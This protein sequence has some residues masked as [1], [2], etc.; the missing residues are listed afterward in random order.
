MNRPQSNR[1]SDA[2]EVA[3][4]VLIHSS[5]FPENVRRDLLESLRTRALNH[6]FHYDSIKQAQKWLAV[7]QAY[8]PAQ[9]DDGCIA[10]Y[11]RSV[12][13][14]AAACQ[15]EPELNVIGLGCGSGQKEV[16]LLRALHQPRRVVR[17]F[18][19]DASAAMVLH[20]TREARSVISHQRCH[21]FVFD[22]ASVG[23]L[24]GALRSIVPGPGRRAVTFFGMLPNFEPNPVLSRLA[25]A[26]QPDDLLLV[27][28]NLAP[29]P[30]Y[31]RGIKR[32]LPQYDNALTR[33]WLLTFLLDL[34]IERAD[35]GIQF[36]IENCP[37][38]MGLK[39][40]A[41]YFRFSRDRQIRIGTERF[42]VKV[43]AEFRLFFSYRY[44]PGQLQDLLAQHRLAVRDQWTTSSGEEGVFYCQR[45]RDR[46]TGASPQ[47]KAKRKPFP[48]TR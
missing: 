39:R 6:K 21:P 18:P 28:A 36:V 8:S 16:R 9:T 44:T 11:E 22:L 32:V 38:A 26:M 17:Y 29:G 23:D 13:A 33:D 24:G 47:T 19:C 3:V 31:L 37:T 10:I 5:Q 34:G 15:G 35:G 48:P 2:P 30:D 7:H 40:I 1:P 25:Q 41:A 14:I 46:Q 12:Q 43:G 45:R 42:D 4:S 27:G 20:A